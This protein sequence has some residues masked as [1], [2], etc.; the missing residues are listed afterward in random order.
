M[1][2]GSVK[3]I[4]IAAYFQHAGHSDYQ[5]QSMCTLISALHA[6][7][8]SQK[9]STVLTC[10]VKA[11][12]GHLEGNWLTNADDD[13]KHEDKQMVDFR[14]VGNQPR[15]QCDWREDW[16]RAWPPQKS[17]IVVDAFVRKQTAQ[18]A[19]CTRNNDNEK[20][21][22]FI[23]T[24]RRWFWCCRNAKATKALDLMSDHK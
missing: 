12:V 16:L 8:C 15:G 18:L 4:L 7:A 22:G 17:R 11:R 14:H 20:P 2:R 9:Y 19:T 21:M 13:D 23:L 1:R 3:L 24:S 6:E 5:V 10:D